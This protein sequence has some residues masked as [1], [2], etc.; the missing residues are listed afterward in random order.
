LALQPIIQIG[1]RHHRI[2]PW[3]EYP[4][5]ISGNHNSCLLHTIGTSYMERKRFIPVRRG[6]RHSVVRPYG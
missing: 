6:R 3:E 5:A 2:A 1:Q 4:K